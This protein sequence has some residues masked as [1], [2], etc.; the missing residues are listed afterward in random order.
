MSESASYGGMDGRKAGAM[1]QTGPVGSEA[2]ATS[3]F[4]DSEEV[5]AALGSL[6][7]Q[8][9]LKLHEIEKVYLRGTDLSPKD[10]LHEAVC[11]VI[12]GDRKCPRAVSP[13]AFI[14]QTMRSLAN[15]RRAKHRRE[16]ADGGVAQDADDGA[17][18]V[19]FSAAAPSPEDVLLQRESEDTVRLIHDVF[20]GDHE[21][22][23]V[24]LGWS[25][26]YRGKE[27]RELVGVDQAALDYA[28]KCIRRT[29]T[30]RYP[31]GWKKS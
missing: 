2:A 12:M 20:E 16:M 17:T 30:K 9:K 18:A 21:P 19:M 25:E 4:L 6:S 8:D 14:V 10:L 7:A 1:S 26:G 22:Q 29:M 28:I 23:M 11:A 5:A 31:H 13:M 27:L 3:G 24:I 15:H